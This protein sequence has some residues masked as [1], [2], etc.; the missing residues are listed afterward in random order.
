IALELQD[1]FVNVLARLEVGERLPVCIP[2]DQLDGARLD[3]LAEY[4]CDRA[5]VC[6]RQDQRFP[7]ALELQDNFVNVLARLEVGERLPVCIPD[8][9]L[10]GARLDLLA[11]YGCDRARVCLSHALPISIALE[12]QDNFVNV[13]ARLEVGERLPVCIP[14]DQLDGAAS[15]KIRS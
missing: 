10:D 14:D 15:R 8:D 3:L 11:E 7:I 9:Q 12:L 2:D 6:R 5:R 13:L 4:G 1:S